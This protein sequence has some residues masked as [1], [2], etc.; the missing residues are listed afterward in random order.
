MDIDLNPK[1]A[2]SNGKSS[3]QESHHTRSSGVRKK[4]KSKEK[5]LA[6]FPKYRLKQYQQKSSKKQK[7]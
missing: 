6:V 3:A 2:K 5:N 7:K 1:S 4:S